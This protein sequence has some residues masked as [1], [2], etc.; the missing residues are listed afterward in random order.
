MAQTVTTF[1]ITTPPHGLTNK[2]PALQS[3]PQPDHLDK[4]IIGGVLAVVFITLVCVVA[5]IFVY[6]YKHKGSYSTYEAEQGGTGRE[7]EGVTETMQ[8]KEEEES[9]KEAHKEHFV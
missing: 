5:V 9:I 2:T 4:A 3:V 1:L 7:E 8:L 6:L